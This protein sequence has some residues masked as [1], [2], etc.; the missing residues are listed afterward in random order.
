M[1]PPLSSSSKQALRLV[2]RMRRVGIAKR[3]AAFSLVQRC[4]AIG[5]CGGV[6]DTARDE[7]EK[8]SGKEINEKPAVRR[9]HASARVTADASKENTETL[10]LRNESLKGVSLTAKILSIARGRF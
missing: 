1:T 5:R 9:V 8:Q 3:V 4:A 2:C 7:R 10:L 6:S